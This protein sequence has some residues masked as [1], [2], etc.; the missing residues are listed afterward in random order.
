MMYQ[1]GLAKDGIDAVA[2]ADHW[3][4]IEETAVETG[5]L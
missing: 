5:Y 4:Q 1:A 2:A 3:C